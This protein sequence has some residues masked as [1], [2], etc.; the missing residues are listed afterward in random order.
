MRR[1]PNLAAV[2]AVAAF[3]CSTSA[4]ADTWNKSYA[5]SSHAQLRVDSNDGAVE[6]I[7]GNAKQISARVETESWKISSSE[8]RIDEHQSGDSVE[9]VVRVPNEHFHFFGNNIRRSLHIY[10]EVPSQSDLDIHTGDGSITARDV[11]GNIRLDTGD[12]SMRVDGMKGTLRFHSGDGRIE[13]ERLDGALNADSGDGSIMLRG[14][15]DVVD[16]HSGDGHIELTAETGSRATGPWSVRT[17][18]GRITVRLPESFGAELDAHTGDGRI[19]IDF[20]VTF[21]GTMN[22]SNFRGKIG[23]GGESVMLRSG[24]GSISI[25]KL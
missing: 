20:P 19:S 16:A 9:I 12:G 6:V 1:L 25:Q 3:V 23:N 2:A 8:V 24:D 15:F 10:L 4:K 17:G 14:R 18:D 7:P 5:V 13:G 22:S 21:S 11:A